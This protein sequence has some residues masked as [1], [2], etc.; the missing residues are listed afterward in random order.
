MVQEGPLLTAT[1]APAIDVSLF[2]FA[3]TLFLPPFLPMDP[4]PMAYSGIQICQPFFSASVSR[5]HHHPGYYLLLTPLP[6]LSLGPALP[7]LLDPLSWLNVFAFLFAVPPP[8]LFASVTATPV[9]CALVCMVQE[10][11]L[12]P[13]SSTALCIYPFLYLSLSRRQSF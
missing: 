11:P 13:L 7:P 8:L 2:L 4:H 6:C 12:F 3:V 10:D 1:A 5:F 9:L